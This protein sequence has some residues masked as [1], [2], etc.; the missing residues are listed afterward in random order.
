MICAIMMGRYISVYVGR[1]HR[2]MGGLDGAGID[3]SKIEAI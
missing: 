2:W 3:R 1:S